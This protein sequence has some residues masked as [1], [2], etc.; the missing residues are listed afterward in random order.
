MEKASKARIHAWKAGKYDFANVGGC[1]WFDRTKKD[2][3]KIK[4][5]G[6]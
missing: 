4:L 2:G 1:K 6:T 3:S 5:Q